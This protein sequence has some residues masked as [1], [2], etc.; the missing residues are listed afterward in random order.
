MCQRQYD[1]QREKNMKLT[2]IVPVYNEAECLDRF[3]EEMDCFLS[4]TPIQTKVLFVDD[5]STDQS[6]EIIKTIHSSDPTYDYIALKTNCGLS[7]A[8][9]AGID[10]CQTSLLGYIDAD[11]QT[12]PND[13]IEM[14]Q[15][16]PEYDMVSGIRVMR[17]DTK[18]KKLSSKIAN[19]YRKI[20]IRDSI[21]DT[22]C[23]LKIMKTEYAKK[24]L[25]FDGM[26][27]F[28]PALVQYQGGKVKQVPVRHYP[29]YAG[30]A[31]YNLRNRLFSPFIDTFAVIWMKRRH[32]R[33]NLVGLHDA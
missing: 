2:V 10:F 13:F 32:I 4:A 29:R 22:C 1:I 9:K 8:I 31:K 11:L 26:H 20:M 16:I 15:Y 7:T 23:P 12:L 6:N 14:L 3:R 21:Q 33:Y 19:T 24:I 25:F 27:R 17:R 18:V 28:I 5:G 30:T